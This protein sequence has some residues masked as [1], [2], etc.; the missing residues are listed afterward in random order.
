MALTTPT[1]K[2]LR[3]LRA[4]AEKIDRDEAYYLSRHGEPEA[5]SPRITSIDNAKAIR[6]VLAFVADYMRE[7]R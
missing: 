4:L 3:R 5:G 1:P 6:A 7:R 2:D